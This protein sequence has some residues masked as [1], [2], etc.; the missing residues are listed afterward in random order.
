MRQVLVP[1]SPSALKTT[2]ITGHAWSFHRIAHE[3]GSLVP[4]EVTSPGWGVFLEGHE[5]ASG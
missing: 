2:S 1:V 5:I 4:A 3:I